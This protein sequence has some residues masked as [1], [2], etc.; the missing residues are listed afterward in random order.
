M[1]EGQEELWK[2]GAGEYVV[3]ITVQKRVHDFLRQLRAGSFC[4]EFEN[5]V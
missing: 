3:T 1:L 2:L 4:A 5:V